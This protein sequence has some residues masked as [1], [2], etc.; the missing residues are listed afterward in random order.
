MSEKK[1]WVCTDYTAATYKALVNTP[2][3]IKTIIIANPTGADIVAAVQLATTAG[4]ARATLVPSKTI[5]AGDSL[6]LDML[7]M[8]VGRN[9]AIMV[10][11]ASTGLHFTASGEED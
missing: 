5:L 10:K 3:K 4:V 9:D 11:G 1:N 8:S 2:G 7:E 6:T